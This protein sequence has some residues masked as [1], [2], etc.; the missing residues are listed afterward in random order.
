MRHIPVFNVPEEIRGLSLFMYY[1]REVLKFGLQ[2]GAYL[3]AAAPVVAQTQTAPL[4]DAPAPFDSNIVLNMART[5]AAKPFKAPDTS[6]PSPFS[7][8]TY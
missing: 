4:A 2:A 7:S 8:L 3:T 5:L 6:L 1:R